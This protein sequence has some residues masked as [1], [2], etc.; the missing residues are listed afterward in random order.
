[1]KKSLSSLLILGFVTFGLVGCGD[2]GTAGSETGNIGAGNEPIRFRIAQSTWQ[3][4]V[5]SDW[6]VVTPPPQGAILVAQH[7][8][9]NFIIAQ[10]PGFDSET[11]Q[12][13]LGR[14][15]ADFFSFE[16]MSERDTE[17][18]FD[19]R[20]SVQDPLRRFHQKILPVTGTNSYLI[21]VCSYE[22]WEGRSHSCDQILNLWQTEEG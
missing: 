14:A 15:E 17:W 19:G 1:M 16:L 22:Y 10:K 21:G 8:D 9:H 12:R 5:P 7:Q 3:S 18:V 6:T 2:D 13:I 4:R 20:R 11:K